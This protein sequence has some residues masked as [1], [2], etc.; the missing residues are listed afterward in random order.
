MSQ[1]ERTHFKNLKVNALRTSCIKSSRRLPLSALQRQKQPPKVF[2]EKS[3]PENFRKFTG[4][5]L[6]HSLFFNQIA[7]LG[8]ATLLKKRLWH[9]C[10]AVNVL[11]FLRTPF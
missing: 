1:N 5:Q 9:R 7:C 10:F 8:P 2:Y 3:V 11:K 4:K 6:C